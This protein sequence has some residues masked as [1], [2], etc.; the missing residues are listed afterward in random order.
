MLELSGSEPTESIA[1]KHIKKMVI[2][3]MTRLSQRRAAVTISMLLLWLTTTVSG[4]SP[5][6]IGWTTPRSA[7]LHP[8]ASWHLRTQQQHGKNRVQTGELVDKKQT[9][10]TNGEEKTAPHRKK[11]SMLGFRHLAAA[12]ALALL[13]AVVAPKDAAMSG[14]LTWLWRLP[15]I[16]PCRV[17]AWVV[18]FAASRSSGGM[19]LVVPTHSFVGGRGGHYIPLIPSGGSQEAISDSDAFGVFVVYALIFLG[20]YALF[21]TMFFLSDAATNL[22]KDIAKP[23]SSVVKLSVAVDVPSRDD[24]CSLLSVLNRLAHSS[25]CS[26]REDVQNLTSQVAVEL[27]RRKSSI[28][29]ASS[30][31]QR[32]KKESER[33][34]IFNQWSV[35][36]RSKFEEE[37]VTK[38]SIIDASMSAIGRRGGDASGSKA[39]MAVVTLVL[40]MKDDFIKISKIRSLTDVEAALRRI[41][42]NVKVDDYLTGMEIM[43]TPLDR[44]EN[45]SRLDVVTHYPELT[46][47]Q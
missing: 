12:T 41:A 9:A 39:T 18:S 31:Y 27:L 42:A 47:V 20:A 45:L 10:T 3:S 29:S 35:Q 1:S 30:R 43:W 8:S 17:V 40:S 21:P 11:A 15:Q 26:S 36:E 14:G 5:A 33:Q 38:F 4:F 32:V 44:N 16:L 24:P 46:S 37:S 7:T 13:L 2:H 25:K 28:Q 34:R 23:S 22:S 6:G 19:T